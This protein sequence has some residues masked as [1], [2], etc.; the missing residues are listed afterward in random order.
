[1]QMNLWEKHERVSTLQKL[2]DRRSKETHGRPF[3]LSSGRAHP[4]H[5]NGQHLL[6][7][8]SLTR[9]LLCHQRLSTTTKKY[10]IPLELATGMLNL[11]QQL[12]ALILPGVAWKCC[13]T[14]RDRLGFLGATTPIQ[15]KRMSEGIPSWPVSPA[16]QTG[17]PDPRLGLVHSFA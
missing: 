11:F 1:M 2:R 4:L 15:L 10:T 14:C 3:C 12:G 8:K 7:C 5:T 13:P 17:S 9:Q 16:L 6:P